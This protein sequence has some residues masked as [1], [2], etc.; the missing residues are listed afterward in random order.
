MYGYIVMEDY[1]NSKDIMNKFKISKPT[2]WA[3]VKNGEFLKPIRIGGRNFWKVSEVE[4]YINNLQEQQKEEK[5]LDKGG[6]C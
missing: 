3:W 4:Q 5:G 6:K 1:Y 2:L